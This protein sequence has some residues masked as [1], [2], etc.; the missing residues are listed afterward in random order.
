[1]IALYQIEGM[2]LTSKKKQKKKKKKN[3]TAILRGRGR[4]NCSYCC[5]V[6]CSNRPGR[7]KGLSFYGMML[8]AK[9]FY[10]AR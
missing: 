10:L 1:M 8:I 2:R 9:D 3:V 4:K 5:V 7:D 6:A